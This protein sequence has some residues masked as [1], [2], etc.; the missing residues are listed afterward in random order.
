[1]TDLDTLRDNTTELARAMVNAFGEY[2]LISGR[3]SP[4]FEPDV[5]WADKVNLH[6][7]AEVIALVLADA[8]AK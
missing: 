4:N 3:Y 5:E 6:E 1:M 2:G 8:E 7:V